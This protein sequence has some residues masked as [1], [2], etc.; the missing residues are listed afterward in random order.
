MKARSAW[1]GILPA[2]ILLCTACAG[3]PV[4]G[5]A[6]PDRGLPPVP[7][8][9]GPL[10]ISIVYPDSLT[11][12]EVE[13]SS[14]VFG[15]LGD[16][17]ATLRIN[18][19]SVPVAPN[20]AWLAW[21]PFR[22]DSL[23]TLLLEARTATDSARREYRIRRAPRFV[24]PASAALW[25]DTTSFSPVGRVWWPGDRYLALSVRASEGATLLLRLA[26][27]ATLPLAA[28]RVPDPAPEALRAFDRDTLRLQRPLRAE[29]YRAVLR[30]AHFGDPGSLLGGG[31]GTPGAEPVLE[32]SKGS[33]T[34]RI[35]WPLRLALL[36]TLPL[37]A[38][39]DDDPLRRG[40]A[41]GISVGRAAP[42]A[43]YT[44]FF[45][46]G[47]RARVSGRV[48]GDLRLALSSRSEAWVAA[49]EASPLPGGF[50]G[51]QVIGSLT[52]TPR[53]D[54]VIARIPVGA[55]I[56]YQVLEAERALSVLLYGVV[57][58]L[59]WLRYG[60]EDSLVRLAT[61][62]Q[63]AADELEL[64]FELSAPVWGYRARWE[65]TDLLFEIRRPPRIDPQAPLRG[66]TIVVDPGH[67][68]AGATGPTGWTEAQANLGIG[69]ILTELLRAEGARVLLTRSD[70]RPLELWPRIRF[71]D[72][73]DAEI[74]VS[75]HNNAL[76]DGV[77]PFSNSGS[78]AF[79]NHPRAL[80]LARAI[81]QRLLAHFGLRDLGVARGD[82]ALVRPTWMPAVL[83]E[84]LF[85]MLPEQEAALRNPAGQR[86]YA[87]AVLEGLRQFLAA[88]AVGR[89]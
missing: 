60:A 85:M 29:R 35:R 8:A 47:T 64:R 40:N 72:S 1:R 5:T 74:L 28:A 58:D 32:A 38:E 82:L 43:T 46:T 87:L 26:D 63:L 11:R 62:H 18:G 61:S 23:V 48:N 6:A 76:P 79:Y 21:I 84:G 16:G 73:V 4:P 51:P 17:A 25:V 81:Q 68:P 24:P 80:P 66:R 77:N 44:W 54:R 52:L 70:G 34:L 75:L 10:R 36:D 3:R 78:S 33:D 2:L 49:S 39:L 27:G 71:A 15:S 67:P 30:G 50:L 57:S 7:E 69:L 9:H 88:R 65:G 45:P 19:A 13:D 14:F 42:A 56:P 53:S 22:G 86:R 89:W 55:R 20:G 83:T 59:N 31:A 12:V 37:L 41:D